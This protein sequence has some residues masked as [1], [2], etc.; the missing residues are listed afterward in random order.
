MLPLLPLKNSVLY[1]GLMLPLAVGRPS[2]LAAVD[3]ALATEEKE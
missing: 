1:P 3:A 2:S